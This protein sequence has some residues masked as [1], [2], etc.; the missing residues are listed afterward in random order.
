MRLPEP[1]YPVFFGCVAAAVV[2]LCAA[3]YGESRRPVSVPVIWRGE[4]GVIYP[5]PDVY[6][7]CQP[8]IKM[9]NT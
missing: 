7:W 4:C 1:N 2:V 8:Q 9:R 3:V 5:T 6:A